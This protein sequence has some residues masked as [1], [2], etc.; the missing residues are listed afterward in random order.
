MSCTQA[1]ETDP[2]RPPLRKGGRLC[3]AGATP[4]LPPVRRGGRGGSAHWLS[5]V[6]NWA[7]VVGLVLSAWLTHPVVAQGP[8]ER[9]RTNTIGMIF[10]LVPAGEFLMGSAAAEIDALRAEMAEH[11]VTGTWYLASPP[12]EGPQHRVKITRAF[13]MGAHEVTVGQFRKFAER[14]GYRTTAES[15]GKGGGGRSGT[16]W[17]QRPEYN[18][19]NIGFAQADDQAVV[20]VTWEDATAFCAWLSQTEGRPHRLPTEAEWEYACRAGSTTRYPWG[21]DAGGRDEYVWHGGHSDG[22]AGPHRVGLL[23]PNALGLYDMCGNVYEYCLDRYAVDAYGLSPVEDPAG[24]V[25]GAAH[26]VRGGSWATLGIHCRPAFRGG[27][28]G[29]G[30][31]N[32]RDGFRVVRRL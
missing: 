8:A 15:D 10:V 9:V 29:P 6:R 20:N 22:L 26:V 32:Q 12:S 28:S 4:V 31:R 14:A 11:K 25:E 27:D 23:K 18:W 7:A 3:A 17:E 21:D 24:P 1:S 2:P 16:R 19:K 5:N 13:E 30:H